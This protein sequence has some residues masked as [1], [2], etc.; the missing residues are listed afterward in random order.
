MAANSTH[1]SRADRSFWMQQALERENDDGESRLHGNE[2][3]DVCIVG[4]GYTGLW[5]AIRIAELEPSAR[6]GVVESDV[7][8]AG[9]SGANG[10][11]AMT[12]WPKFATLTKLM[13]TDDALRLAAAS[14]DAVARIGRFCEDNAIDADF[15]PEGWLWA[16]TNTSQVGSWNETIRALASAGAYPIRELSRKEVLDM[17]GSERHLAGVFEAGVAT[18]QPAALVRGLRTNAIAAGVRVWEDTPMSSF[19]VT[20]KAV[21]INVPGGRILAG[22]LVLATNAWLARYREI[23]RHLLVLGSDV[24]A[25]APAPERLASVGPTKGLAISDS[26]R[27]VH[28]YRSTAEGRMVFGKGGGRLGFRSHMNRSVWAT[29]RRSRELINQFHLTY[30]ALRD[31]AIT[32]TWSGAVD[33]SSD[34]L[35]FF[36]KLRGSERVHFGVGF[37][38]NGV[39]P[40]YLGGRI[41]A[42]LALGRNDEWGTCP[43][44]RKPKTHLPP[45]PFRALGGRIVRTA[46]V[47]KETAEDMGKNPTPLVRRV[48]N[49]DPTSFVG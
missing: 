6:V 24:I 12:W 34:S 4:G 46:M 3:L 48:T 14:Q 43:L 19:E 1:V 11:L 30:P 41:L 16:A 39:G 22:Q 27:L 38:G 9:A 37:S 47:K 5:T 44:I 7:C 2:D 49:L 17:G 26:R 20:T 29:S 33:Y 15:M 25:T 36:G 28:Y 35:P 23:R 31:E 21:Q 18:V 42:S 13:S 10:G 45:E 8:G 40:S 32:H